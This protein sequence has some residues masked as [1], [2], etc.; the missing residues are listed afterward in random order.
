MPTRSRNV[1]SEWGGLIAAAMLVLS[2]MAHAGT[3]KRCFEIASRWAVPGNIPASN[4]AY[5]VYDRHRRELYRGRT[6][7]KGIAHICVARLPSDAT[8]LLDPDGN[9]ATPMPI[10]EESP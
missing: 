1:R 3:D 5:A 8:M 7:D 2:G 9:S 6:D 10:F 4:T